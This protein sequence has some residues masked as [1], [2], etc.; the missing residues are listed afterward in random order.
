MKRTKTIY[1]WTT[2]IVL[3]I[4]VKIIS[5]LMELELKWY[6]FVIL[7]FVGTTLGKLL[8]VIFSGVNLSKVVIID[9][10]E[11][12]IIEFITD[13]QLGFSNEYRINGRIADHWGLSEEEIT[14]MIYN[15][16][17]RKLF[18]SLLT[19]GEKKN[20]Q[21][22]SRSRHIEIKYSI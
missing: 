8:F 20:F 1:R 15:Q 5:I 21:Y 12:G 9:S 6:H 16:T 2:L 18:K 10:A 22:I 7:F 11:E 13:I 17:P 14:Q 4:I 3:T 19:T